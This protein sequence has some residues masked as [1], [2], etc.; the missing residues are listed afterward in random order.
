MSQTNNP[1]TTFE[2]PIPKINIGGIG[3][4]DITLE[5]TMDL[6]DA[7]IEQKQKKR[8]C[9]TPVNCVV[10]ANKNES[11]QQLY[12]TADLT[13]CDGVPLIW[14]SKFLGQEKLR[15]R[16]TGLDLLPQYIERCYQRNFSMFFLGAAEGVAQ[17]FKEQLEEK[18]PGIQVVG[19]Y[20][21]PYANE[22]SGEENQK[23]IDIINAANPDILWVSLTAPKQDYWIQQNYP[24]LNSSINIGIGAALDV[25]VG[26]FNRAP[27][28]M[29][30][31]G[32][33]WFY[34]FIKEPKRLFRRYF[35]EA[36]TFIPIIIKQKIL[37]K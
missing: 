17:R 14:A 3:I 23:M 4:S 28:W 6:F 10:W 5:E 34:R 7:W 37:E 9:V 35:I 22:F 25:A 13:L 32:L 30:K 1:I 20:S 33:E 15:G 24:Q 27:I 11:L 12:N 36:P 29:Q 18:Y 2:N 19:V 31:S 8:I 16:V 26:K 21:P